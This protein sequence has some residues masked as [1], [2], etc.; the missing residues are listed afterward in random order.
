MQP[1]RVFEAPTPSYE[2]PDLPETPVAAAPSWGL[3]KKVLFRFAAVY[4]LLYF[5]PWCLNLIPYSQGVTRPVTDFS[6]ELVTSVGERVFGVHAESEMT[7]SG[8]TTW[9]YVR[10]F[11]LLVTAA[12]ATVVWSILDRKRPHYAR[13]YSWL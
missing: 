10:V 4:F 1:E 8:D 7:G 3:G 6:S 9:D 13:L 5:L 12:A 11:C 2:T